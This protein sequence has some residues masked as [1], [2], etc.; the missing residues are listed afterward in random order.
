[1]NFRSQK[2]HFISSQCL[3]SSNSNHSRNTVPLTSS[4]FL[5]SYLGTCVIPLLISTFKRTKNIHSKLQLEISSSLSWNYCIPTSWTLSIV[6]Y[7]CFYLKC[8]T[9]LFEPQCHWPF[10]SPHTSKCV[11]IFS[12]S[13]IDLTHEKSILLARSQILSNNHLWYIQAL[14]HHFHPPLSYS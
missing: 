2:V 8:C 14:S 9:T 5:A 1:V 7:W 13:I 6:N 11:S 12:M 10:R 3:K 4:Y